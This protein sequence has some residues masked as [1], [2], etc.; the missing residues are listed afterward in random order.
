M[1]ALP[2]I[3]ER[4]LADGCRGY[5]TAICFARPLD[6]LAVGSLRRF[7]AF[8]LWAPPCGQLITPVTLDKEQKVQTRAVAEAISSLARLDGSEGLG[9][10]N[11]VLRHAAT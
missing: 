1:A 11:E 4:G 6:E 7:A 8:G 9:R 10:G 5:T 3:D 2:A